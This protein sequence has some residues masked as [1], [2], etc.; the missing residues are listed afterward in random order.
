MVSNDLK[1]ERERG[2]LVRTELFTH[3][4][5]PFFT[6]LM[7]GT[8]VFKTKPLVCILSFLTSLL[9]FFFFHL[10]ILFLSI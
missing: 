1:G 6:I 8:V 4:S 2:R 7:N 3:Y 10:S 5:D 9:F